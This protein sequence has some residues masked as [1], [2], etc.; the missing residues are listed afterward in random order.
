MVAVGRWSLAQV[1]LYFYSYHHFFTYKMN[2]SP[3]FSLDDATQKVG[4]PKQHQELREWRKRVRESVCDRER[5]LGGG[6]RMIWAKQGNTKLWGI[7]KIIIIINGP[8]THTHTHTDNKTKKKKDRKGN[9]T[10]SLKLKLNL[11]LQP[12]TNDLLCVL[13]KLPGLVVNVEDSQ[14]ELW[15]LD[16]SSIPGFA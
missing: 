6:W 10:S 1:C 5:E 3:F 16:A 9:W 2:A 12:N 13:G 11:I 15:S 7:I 4:H 14:S 8:D